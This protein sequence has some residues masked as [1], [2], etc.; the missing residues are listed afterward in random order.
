MLPINVQ[1]GDKLGGDNKT[2]SLAE[3]E[4]KATSYL[5]AEQDIVATVKY[6]AQK[7]GQPVI[8]VGSSY[9]AALALKVG[10]E[11]EQV[12]AVAA[13]SPGEYFRNDKGETFIRDA[14]KGFNKPLFLTS[15]QREGPQAKMFYD[16]AVSELK[17]H[18]IPKTEGIH[19]ARA[20]WSS[21]DG[22][23]DYWAAFKDFLKELK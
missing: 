22:S 17:V 16:V 9:S 2:A 19:G 13:F 18:F 8:L 20:L 3:K 12:R 10:S 14:M 7:Y 11:S 5:D 1:E 21:T 4:G 6:A 23:D 15:S